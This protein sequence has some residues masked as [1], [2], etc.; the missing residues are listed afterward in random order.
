MKRA[1]FPLPLFILP[2]GYTRLRIFE[3]RYLT[4]VKNAIKDNSG[5]VLC[6]FEHDTPYNIA[7]Q[8]CLV[9]I[10]DFDQDDSGMLL[11]DVLA[12]KSVQIKA[13]ELNSDA[14]RIAEVSS[15]NTPYWY[16]EAHHAIGEHQ[17]LHD[18]LQGVFANNPELRALYKHTQFDKLCWIVARWLELLPISINKKQQL[19]FE[20]NFDKL[21]TFLHTVINNEFT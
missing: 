2:D 21:L 12:M 11:I 8:G 13:V 3:P 1:I 10:I 4:M 9:D 17:H 15:R 19:A 14:L 5:F 18:T 20:T 16:N 6:S 7:A